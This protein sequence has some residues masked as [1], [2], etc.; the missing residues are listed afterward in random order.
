MANVVPFSFAQ[1]LLKGAHNFTTNT[2]KLALYTAGSGAPYSTSSTVYSSG[3]ANEVSGA[4]YTTGGNTLTSP[5]VAN[6]SNVATLT[7]AQTQFTSAT[8]GAAYAVIYNNS[9]SDKLVVVLDFGGTKSCSNG[10][11]TITF[12]ST[13]SGTPAGTDSL[14]S[15]TS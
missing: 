5:V 15:I 12:P 4:G 7:F 10:T 6:Q 3:V 2:I 1:E 8:F 14:I 13:S 11:F 9:A